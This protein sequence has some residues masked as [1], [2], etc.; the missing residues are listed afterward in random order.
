MAN[1]EIKVRLME[2]G[3]Y[4]SINGKSG[5]F[6]ADDMDCVFVGKKD[7]YLT[8]TAIERKNVG[9][10]GQTHFLKPSIPTDKFKAMTQEEKQNIPIIGQIRP[11]GRETVKPEPV[12]AASVEVLGDMPAL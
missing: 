11:M 9:E 12:A 6:I 5:V 8:L 3:Q 2:L 1:L 7:I 10:D 4:V